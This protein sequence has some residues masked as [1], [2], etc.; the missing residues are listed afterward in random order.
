MDLF[1]LDL[2]VVVVVKILSFL[3]GTALQHYH[4][5]G[6]D[7]ALEGVVGNDLCFF[8]E[9]AFEDA[10][11]EENAFALDE[12]HCFLAEGDFPVERV[13]QRSVDQFHMVL[14]IDEDV[15]ESDFSVKL[16]EFVDVFECVDHTDG[17]F[18]Y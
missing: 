14:L 5:H 7:V 17:N 18:P 10:G 4:P 11:A 3:L 1:V 16:F 6:P 9:Q 8:M 13:Q 2:E 15:F 12:S